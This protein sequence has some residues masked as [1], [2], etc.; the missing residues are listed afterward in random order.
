MTKPELI[1]KLE[2]GTEL[3]MG[4]ESPNQN[5]PGESVHSGWGGYLGMLAV[6]Q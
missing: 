2:Q 4:K 1:I 5:P 3:W 6:L